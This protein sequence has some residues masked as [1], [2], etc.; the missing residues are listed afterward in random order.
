MK[1][2]VT[3]L[4][5]VATTTTQLDGNSSKLHTGSQ[6][7]FPISSGSVSYTITGDATGTATLYFDRSG[8]RTLEYRELI[9]QRFGITSTEKTIDF[10][11]GDYN[12]KANLN[13]GRGKKQH[14]STWSKLL[15]YK[16]RQKSLEAIMEAK[17]GQLEGTDVLLGKICN[18]W[19][20]QSGT[21]QEVWEWGGIPLKIKK[22]LPGINY[23]LQAS[24]IT[25]QG[26]IP[27]KPL[28]SLEGIDWE[29]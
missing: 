16:T 2:I 20:F 28:S 15:N 9:L 29:N 17:G 8:W 19:A 11:D 1:T 26:T 21:T 12:Y 6:P 24:S 4:L 3:L 25:N 13:A 14:D 18:I 22:K 27:E 10:T 23:E 7:K 5:L